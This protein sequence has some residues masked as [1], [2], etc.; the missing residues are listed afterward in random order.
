MK[1]VR[2]VGARYLNE[3][4]ARYNLATEAT[5]SEKA[6]M[7]EMCEE[8][9]DEKIPQLAEYIKALSD[10][11]RTVENIAFLI[12]VEATTVYVEVGQDGTERIYQRG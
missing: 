10:T 11:D 3:M 7:L 9:T 12:A 6:I 5:K 8:C 4:L 2:N 1:I